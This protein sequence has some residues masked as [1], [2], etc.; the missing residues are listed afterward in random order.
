MNEEDDCW[1]ER[2]T[3]KY[4]LCFHKTIDKQSMEVPHPN[5]EVPRRPERIRMVSS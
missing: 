3:N 2:R 5:L 4:S 1:G